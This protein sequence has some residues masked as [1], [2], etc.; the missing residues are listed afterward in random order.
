MYVHVTN[1]EIIK[2]LMLQ[3][4]AAKNVKPVHDRSAIMYLIP[5][6]QYYFVHKIP[7]ENQETKKKT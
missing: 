5:T 6:I 2:S 1:T 3:R 4:K 7:H